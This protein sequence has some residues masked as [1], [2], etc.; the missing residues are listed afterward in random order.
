MKSRETV[1][2]EK[3]LHMLVRVCAHI[4]IAIII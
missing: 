1:D 3:Q 2:T 4:V